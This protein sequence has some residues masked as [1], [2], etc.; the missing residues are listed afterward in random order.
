M[1]S[2]S[3]DYN[4]VV[5]GAG[6]AGLVTA[7][8]TAGL[9]GRVALI[10]RNKMGG[11]C[12]NF[13][14]VPSKALISSAR[15]I[16]RMRHAADWGLESREPVFTFRAVV[17]RMRA[18][19]AE[20]APHDSQERFESLGVEVFRGG[21]RFI[22]PHE[23]EVNGLTLRAR[24]FVIATG[25]RAAIPQIPGLESVRCL[26]NE[27]L[28]DELEELPQRLLIIG[29][30]A[31]GCE[32]AQVFA[33]FGSKVTLV[34]HGPQLLK[35]EDPT[36][37]AFL[38]KTLERD[39]VQIHTGSQVEQV[40]DESGVAVVTIRSGAET[41]LARFDAVLLAAGRTP[42][43]EELNLSA[44]G[45]KSTGKGVEVNAWL[46]T[47]QPHIYAAGDITGR[48]LFTHMADYQARI[49]VRNILMPLQPL[50]QKADDRVVPW[51]TYTDPEIARVGMNEA[52]AKGAGIAYDLLEQP[53][54]SLDRAVVEDATEGF[55]R[56]LL[57]KRTDEILGATIVGEGAGDLLQPLVLAMRHK[58]GLGKVGSAI[59]PYPSY[60]E[61]GRKLAD[62]Q[63]KSRLTP[64]AKQLFRWLYSRQLRSTR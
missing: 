56:V 22:S 42:N 60:V 33:R 59:H 49:V 11:D 23:V 14:C 4:V 20:I 5:L 12:L 3:K 45:V 57:R 27:T 63:Q 58:L 1:K 35:K 54:K 6:T 51:C 47:S 55:A 21:V 37:A 17:E 2:S 39:G 53:M 61:I 7:A 43:L 26:T 46:Q 50:R 38:Q 9:G 13:G 52:Q 44:A 48:H 16:H 24:H 41:T 10:E 25:T 15:L 64:R 32:M 19:R 8:G 34:Q 30:G 28:F 36:V 62:Q 40:R 31:I 18:R 29:G